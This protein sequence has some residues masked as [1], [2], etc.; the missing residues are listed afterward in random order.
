MSR[1]ISELPYDIKLK[2]MRY[3]N[4]PN[5]DELAASFVWDKT[6]EGHDVWSEIY[7]GNYQPFYNYYSMKQTTPKQW[8]K[9]KGYNEYHVMIIEQY[10]NDIG[11]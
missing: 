9:E 1:L 7:K 10:L 11:K 3:S 6:N 4:V 2:A 5:E 8:C